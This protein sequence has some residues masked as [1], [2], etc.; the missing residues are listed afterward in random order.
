MHTARESTL[1]F[2]STASISNLSISKFPLQGLLETTL[3]TPS[4][5]Q[6]DHK[7][8]NKHKKTPHNPTL[9]L[10][11]RDKF[12]AAMVTT[13]TSPVELEIKKK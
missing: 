11:Y 12:P 13:P 2:K 5:K 1:E 8:K 3:H 9:C 6:G 10:A 7:Q 4:S